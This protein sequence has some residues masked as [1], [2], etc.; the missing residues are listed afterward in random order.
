MNI[1]FVDLKQQ[2]QSIK[3]EID[4]A[5]EN[6]L[7]ETAFIGGKYVN[8]FEKDFDKV[9]IDSLLKDC[10]DCSRKELNEIEFRIKAS[11]SFMMYSRVSEASEAYKVARKM[12]DKLLN[13][14]D[15]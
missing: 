3:N 1:P 6:V 12:L 2:Y 9:R 4:T 11:K 7:T 8:K 15:C 5:I 14:K 10:Q 13:C